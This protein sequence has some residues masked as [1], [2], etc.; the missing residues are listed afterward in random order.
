M[1][2]FVR[3]ERAKYRVAEHDRRDDVEVRVLM[4]ESRGRAEWEFLVGHL[5]DRVRVPR[6]LAEH[7]CLVRNDFSELL[8]YRSPRERAYR[9]C[10]IA[11][12]PQCFAGHDS[13]VHVE[14]SNEERH[15][16]EV[17]I[18]V[19]CK[20]VHTRGRLHSGQDL[21]PRAGVHS[22]CRSEVSSLPF[23]IKEEIGSVEECEIGFGPRVRVVERVSLVIEPDRYRARTIHPYSPRVRIELVPIERVIA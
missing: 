13:A 1:K 9:S 6:H 8:E 7:H 5:H 17:V 3:V 18:V 2:N 20:A 21:P 12:E 23:R 15:V 4:F 11:C 16:D 19:C 10:G 22:Y 14:L